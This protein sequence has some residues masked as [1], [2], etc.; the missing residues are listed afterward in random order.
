[1]YNSKSSLQKKQLGGNKKKK[2]MII[3]MSKWSNLRY[4]GFTNSLK[5]LYQLVRNKKRNPNS[6][7]TE[8]GF[9]FVVSNECIRQLN[10]LVFIIVLLNYQ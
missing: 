5:F 2:Y 9:L 6:V 1:M 7:I 10:Y 4:Y 3:C 8:L